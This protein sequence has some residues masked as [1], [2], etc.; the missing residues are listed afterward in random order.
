M[1]REALPNWMVEQERI[2]S[3]VVT[4]TTHFMDVR[5]MTRWM[6]VLAKTFWTVAQEMIVTSSTGSVIRISCSTAVA[7]TGW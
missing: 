2:I 7:M 1:S 3:V 4:I 6:V 5:V